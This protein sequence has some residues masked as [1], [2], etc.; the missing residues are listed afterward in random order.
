M[1]KE[2]DRVVLTEALP[3]EGLQA[4]DVG[5]IVHV[6]RQG[7]AFDVEFFALNG[8]TLSVA[9]VPASHVRAVTAQDMSHARTLGTP[10]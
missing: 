4:G 1:M 8:N 9:T 10:V 7:E 3:K 2:H 5:V 6:Y